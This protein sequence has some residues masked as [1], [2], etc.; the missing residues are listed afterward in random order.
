[1]VKATLLQRWFWAGAVMLFVGFCTSTKLACN[2]KLLTM[3]NC[4]VL[5]LVN[6]VS[7]RSVPP[8]QLVK[9]KPVPGV[10]VML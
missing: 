6:T 8:V 7:G 10:A 9:A 5:P 1:M 4:T 3:I 2:V